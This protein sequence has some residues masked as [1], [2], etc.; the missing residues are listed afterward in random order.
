MRSTVGSLGGA[1]GAVVRSTALQFAIRLGTPETRGILSHQGRRA[2]AR[3]S[4]GV[5]D[6][7]VTST[8]ERR[9]RATYQDVLDAPA[10]RVAEIVDGTL[11][12]SPRPPSL[13]AL[14]KTCLVANL[15]PEF[16]F[17]RPELA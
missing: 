4:S 14:A 1:G 5:P 10:H 17:G 11:H 6:S 16:C 3:I 2:A 13:Q 9:P 7:M 12:V 8:A 15:G